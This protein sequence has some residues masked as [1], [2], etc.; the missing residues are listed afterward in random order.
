M[1]MKRPNIDSPSMFTPEGIRRIEESYKATYLLDSALKTRDGWAMTS[2]AI[3]YTE[4]AHPEGSN[5]FAMYIDPE[6]DCLM[7]T[8]AGWIEG[9]EF[10]FMEVG[11]ALYHSADRHDYVVREGYA[12]DG[13]RDY[14]RTMG[15]PKLVT[16]AIENGKFYPIHLG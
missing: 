3:F 16:Y 4:V 7:I 9:M 2:G 1:D 11:G 6:T 13:G 14:L 12:I 8:N 5:Y 10:T 15:D